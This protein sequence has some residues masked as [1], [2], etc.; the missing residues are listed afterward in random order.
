MC[1]GHV[2]AA[3]GSK[4]VSRE[5]AEAQAAAVLERAFDK[6]DF[7][8]MEVRASTLLYGSC[9]RVHHLAGSSPR[10][11][12]RLVATRSLT[13]SSRRAGALIICKALHCRQRAT[14]AWASN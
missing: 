12:R 6:A 13:C 14:A 8:R 3:T 4:G 7:K 9:L 5:Q 1:L 2:Q 10:P 11:T